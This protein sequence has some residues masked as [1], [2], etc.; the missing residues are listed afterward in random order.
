MFNY[1]IR[2]SIP[3]TTEVE[4]DYD[5][6]FVNSWV[7]DYRL[8]RA[9]KKS[10]PLLRVVQRVDGSAR[11]YGRSAKADVRQARVNMLSD[12]TIFQSRYGKYATTEKFRVIAGDGPIIYNPVDI[13]KF[14]PIGQSYS[15][16]YPI[17]VCH[18]TFSTNPLKGVDLLYEAALTNRDVDFILCGRYSHSALSELS[19]IHNLGILNINQL[20]E[21]YRACDVFVSFAT[22]ET[23]PNVV[24]EALASGL[25]VLYKDSGGVSELVGECGIPIEIGNFRQGLERA[26]ACRKELSKEARERTVSNFSPDIIFLQYLNAIKIA[27]R[28]PLPTFSASLRSLLS[29]YPIGDFSFRE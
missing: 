12:L 14:T 16:P 20:A 11:D 26:L 29:G 10:R 7:V 22:N 17:K 19:N 8:I 18:V 23:C 4:D 9:I 6:I 24:L 1:L 28:R 21:V 15:L 25:P 3:Y 13:E 2:H 27:K 5:V